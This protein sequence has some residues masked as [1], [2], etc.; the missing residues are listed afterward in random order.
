MSNR[1][2]VAS[3]EFQV[4]NFGGRGVLHTPS[5]TIIIYFIN[6]GQASRLSMCRGLIHRTRFGADKS[7]PYKMQQTF[8][9]FL[10]GRLVDF[11]VLNFELWFFAFSFKFLA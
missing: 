9:T 3:C 11:K 5:L 2:R 7:A 4:Y 8:Y 10:I 1:L 6:V